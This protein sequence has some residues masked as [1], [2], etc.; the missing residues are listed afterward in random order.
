[1]RKIGIILLLL[2]GFSCNPYQPYYFTHYHITADYDPATG[3][4]SAN[5]RMVLVPELEYRDSITLALNKYIEIRSLAAQELKYYEFDS[6]RLVLY[7][8]EAVMPGDQLH[9]S[10]AYEGPIGGGPGRDAW[11]NPEDGWYPVNQDI[12]KMTYRVEMAL[13]DNFSLE[14]PATGNGPS[15]D[16]GSVK[17]QDSIP[18]PALLK[19]GTLK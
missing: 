19:N 18:L 9:I 7:I 12:H 16:F 10:L 14:R 6:G 13:P 8:E 11:L 5:V 4:L 15:W 2:S 1:M 17:P 3:Y